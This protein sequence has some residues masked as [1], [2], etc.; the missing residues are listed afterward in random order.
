MI[1][2]IEFLESMMNNEPSQLIIAAGTIREYDFSFGD[3]DDS[4]GVVL[5]GV[6]QE[7]ALTFPVVLPSAETLSVDI[8]W[9]EE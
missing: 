7:L 2:R 3:V 8:E 4:G 6:A 5:R 1:E 9:T